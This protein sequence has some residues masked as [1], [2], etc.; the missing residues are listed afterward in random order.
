MIWASQQHDID[1]INTSALREILHK[2]VIEGPRLRAILPVV[3]ERTERY[4]NWF[5]ATY[6]EQ[7]FRYYI[8]P[9]ENIAHYVRYGK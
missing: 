6:T 7:Y 9:E 1:I 5:I 3:H 4:F 2:G 8:F